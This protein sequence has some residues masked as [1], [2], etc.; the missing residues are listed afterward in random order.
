MAGRLRGKV[1]V[2]SG[3]GSG[4]GKASAILFAQ[5]GA[6]VVGCDID[7]ATLQQTAA[8]IQ[9]LNCKPAVT[10]VCDMSRLDDARR[11]IELAVD[12]RGGI[13]I[14]YNV[15]GKPQ[16]AWIEEMTLEQWSYTLR[17]ELD[18]VFLACQCAWPHLVKR[19]G[20]SIINVA[21]VSGK[22]AYEGLPAL[23]HTAGKGGVISMTRQL[24]MEG[25]K[26]AIRV[27]SISPG[28]VETAAT[29]EMMKDE[30]W[31]SSRKREVML[32]GRIGQPIDIAYGALYLASDESIW[33]TGADFAIDGGTTAW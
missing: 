26:Y 30:H 3:I 18:S 7:A 16:F 15:V 25:G 11:L 12:A 20:G 29:A 33:V 8:E 28:C 31:L 1:A 10:C 2:I 6:L 23:A 4:I 17:Q 21:S 27:N 14:L 19:G 13:D 5:E 22:I 32:N 9:A 24:A